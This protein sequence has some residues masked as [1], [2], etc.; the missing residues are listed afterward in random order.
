VGHS[1]APPAT[2]PVIVAFLIPLMVFI[3]SFAAAE[4]GSLGSDRPRLL[5]DGACRGDRFGLAV[6]ALRSVGLAG[7]VIAW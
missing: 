2:R 4:K 5:G 3:A 7:S 6:L 1:S